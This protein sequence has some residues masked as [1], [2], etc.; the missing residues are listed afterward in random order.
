MTTVSQRIE[1]L[2]EAWPAEPESDHLPVVALGG[3]SG[4]RVLGVANSHQQADD[5]ATLAGIGHGRV[6]RAMIETS[7]RQF[8]AIRP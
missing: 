2:L 1:R 4:L 7:G 5:L 6:S 3:E 8:Y